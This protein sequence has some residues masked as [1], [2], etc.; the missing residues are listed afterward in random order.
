MDVEIEAQNDAVSPNC[1][2]DAEEMMENQIEDCAVRP[3]CNMDAESSNVEEKIEQEKVNETAAANDEISKKDAEIRKLIEER[4]IS[5]KERLRLKDL[6]KQLRKCI[7]D[8]IPCGSKPIRTISEFLELISR[9][10]FDFRRLGFFC[11]RFK[12]LVCSKVQS[13]TMWPSMCLCCGCLCP[14]SSNSNVVV[15]VTIHDNI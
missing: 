11:E 6:D 5:N 7:K 14:H 1:N 13:H 10:E 3:K 4:N 8:K 15:S 9:F 12:F 2:N